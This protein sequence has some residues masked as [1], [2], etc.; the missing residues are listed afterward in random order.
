MADV[1]TEN[2]IVRVLEDGAMVLVR[3]SERRTSFVVTRMAI[4]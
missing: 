4:S 1:Q 3:R 2:L